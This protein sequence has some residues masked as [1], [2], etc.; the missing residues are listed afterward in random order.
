MDADSKP[1]GNL[2]RRMTP[3]NHLFDCRNLEFFGISLAAH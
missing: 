3:I 1:F 2:R